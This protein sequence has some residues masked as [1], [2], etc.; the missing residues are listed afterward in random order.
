[1]KNENPRRHCV[2]SPSENSG[3]RCR[4]ARSG[5]RRL[6]RATVCRAR[7]FRRTTEL[8]NGRVFAFDHFRAQFNFDGA[9]IAG[10]G[11]ELPG[12][13]RADV[14]RS[15]ILQV[16]RRKKTVGIDRGAD[17]FTKTCGGRLARLDP[18]W[19][20]AHSRIWNSRGPGPRKSAPCRHDRWSA[21]P[22]NQEPAVGRLGVVDFGLADRKRI[23]AATF[24]EVVA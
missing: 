10:I 17:V 4:N 5:A 22:G 16:Q 19:R 14:K 18:N 23:P 3:L 7:F 8:K 24:C 15:E 12:R 21:G 13:R 6:R 2:W 11:H 20:R 1:M 9:A